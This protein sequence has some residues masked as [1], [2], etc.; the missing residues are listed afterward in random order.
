MNQEMREELD[1]ILSKAEYQAYYEDNRSLMQR[2]WDSFRDWL[3]ELLSYFDINLEPSSQVANIVV[4]TIV[5]IIAILLLVLV[6][7][8]IKRI[9]KRRALKSK[10]IFLSDEADWTYQQH[11]D[12]A[13][14]YQNEQQFE[15]ATRHTFLAFL[16]FLQ[17]YD[18]LEIK[19]WKTNWEYANE[20]ATNEPT[21]VSKYQVTANFFEK[22]TYGDESVSEVQFQE[23]F[24]NMKQWMDEWKSTR[25][26]GDEE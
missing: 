16:L 15:L 18:L 19:R 5:F 21:L 14:R 10:N 24:E 23:Y 7:F 9:I 26:A 11:L 3:L 20:L 6:L 4:L 25:K 2:L 8:L 12:E 13:I 17:E 1:S 22:V